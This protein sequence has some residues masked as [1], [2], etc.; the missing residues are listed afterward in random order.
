MVFF[1]D[2]DQFYACTRAL[3][4]RIEDQDPGAADAILASRLVIRLRTTEPTAEITINGRQRPVETTF[5]PS[6]L[7]PTL[8]IELSADTLH[9]IMLGEQS[10]KKTLAGGQLTVRG[11]VWKVTALAD[12][13]Y[14]MQALYPQVLH[15]CQLSSDAQGG[16]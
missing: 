10:M 4:S 9:R 12:L 3:F 5:G 1:T 14:R 7:R 8:D 6:R 2:S 15:E 16:A 13:F 11:P